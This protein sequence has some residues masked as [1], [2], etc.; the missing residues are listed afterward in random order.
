[1]SIALAEQLI[2][3]AV[4]EP[5]QAID[6]ASITL[7][8]T[9]VT[10]FIGRCRSRG[11]TQAQAVA[12]IRSGDGRRRL[13]DGLKRELGS[14]EYKRRGGNDYADKVIAA[15]IAARAADVRSFVAEAYAAE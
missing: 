6:P 2:T 13:R 14:K 12:A 3:E 15:G 5:G 9:L 11:A 1:M 8:L 7:I 10:G 4:S